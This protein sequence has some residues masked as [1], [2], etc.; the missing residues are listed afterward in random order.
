MLEKSFEGSLWALRFMVIFKK[1]KNYFQG[2][3]F[4]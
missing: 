4:E 2:K 1:I 3:Q